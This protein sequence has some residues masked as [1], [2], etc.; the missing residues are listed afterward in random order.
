[1]VDMGK[2]ETSVVLGQIGL[3]G[4][5]DITTEAATAKLMYLLGQGYRGDELRQLLQT[6]LRGELTI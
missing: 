2:Y 5:Y 6:P 4:G 1:S 3:V